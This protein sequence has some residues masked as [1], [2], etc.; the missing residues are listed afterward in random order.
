MTQTGCGNRGSGW[1][2][3][4]CK[5]SGGYSWRLVVLSEAWQP[6][7]C[8]SGED[9]QSTWYFFLFVCS[10]ANLALA[11]VLGNMNYRPGRVSA[12]HFGC[13]CERNDPSTVRSNLVP[14]MDV[15]NMNE[16]DMINPAESKGNGLCTAVSTPTPTTLVRFQF[17]TLCGRKPADGCRSCSFCS[18]CQTG[19]CAFHGVQAEASVSSL[20]FTAVEPQHAV[21]MSQEFGHLL[22]GANRLRK[23]GQLRLLGSRPVP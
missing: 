15:N 9:G 3:L 10:A 20:P 17:Q 4:P 21:E 12:D 22:C 13:K 6:T 16:Y 14:F 1:P 2:T 18:G 7:T 19:Y 8:R 5:I 23:T 11:V